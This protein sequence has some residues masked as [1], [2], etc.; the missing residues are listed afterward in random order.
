[1]ESVARPQPSLEPDMR[2]V[3]EFDESLA[4]RDIRDD[5]F[6]GLVGPIG[7]ATATDDEWRFYL[8]LDD[9]HA[10]IGGVCHGGALATLVDFGMGAAAFR[11]VGHRPVAT[12]ELNVQFI[13]AAKPGNRVHGRSRVLRIVKSIVFMEC[14]ICSQGR[15]V[16]KGTGVW[17]VLDR[18]TYRTVP[19]ADSGGKP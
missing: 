3:L 10:N 13:A 11:A 8:D 18:V 1:M 9:R 16:A 17:K 6:N 14:D 4:Y 19:R 5:G 15:L 7:F 12:I 2:E